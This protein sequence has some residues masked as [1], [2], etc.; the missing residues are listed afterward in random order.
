[1]NDMTERKQRAKQLRQS[2]QFDQ[3]LPIYRTLWAETDDAYDGAGLLHCLRK[4]GLFDEATS[5]ARELI[6]THPSVDWCRNEVIWTM[7]SGT[8]SKYGETSN[9][10]GLV[11]TA[12]EIM[13]F[14]PQG[15]AAKMV[16]FK[17]LK[18]AKTAN[19]WEKVNEWV[20]KIDPDTLSSKPMTDRSGRESWSDQAVWYNYRI[21]SLI[22]KED[23]NEAILLVDSILEK[24][25]KQSKFFLRLRALAQH[26]LGQL[27]EAEKAYRELCKT[28]RPDWWMLCEYARVIRDRGDDGH[29]LELM[30]QAANSHSKLDNMVSL[31]ADIGNLCAQIGRNEEARSHLLLC[32]YVRERNGWSVPQ[33]VVQGI[34]D[35]NSRIP[36]EEPGTTIEE[37]LSACRGFWRALLGPKYTPTG[38]SACRRSVRKGLIGQVKLGHPDRPFCFI[39]T[40]DD[41]SIY[42]FKSDLP[43]NTND[44]DSVRFDAV[45]SFDKKKNR[46]SWK[47]ANIVLSE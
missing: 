30:C 37:E 44:G 38:K 26:S 12:K 24:F 29:A 8:L 43:S 11:E 34:R 42:C 9:L 36:G 1:M 46:E 41:K 35:L 13:D 17:V 40:N 18:A 7:I 28:H 21:K 20:T 10:N 27:D 3:A 14:K 16:V 19:D 15:V 6:D 31:F 2:H 33:S 22:K 5:F 25:P 32:K 47:A 39:V 45:P 4:L 23:F